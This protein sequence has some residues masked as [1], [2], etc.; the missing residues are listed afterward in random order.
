VTRHRIDYRF[1]APIS[2]APVGI[3][4]I[5]ADVRKGEDAA[6][7][8]AYCNRPAGMPELSLKK[9]LPEEKT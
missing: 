6:Q 9:Y 2:S 5:V 7:I 8:E 4:P 3:H 1:L